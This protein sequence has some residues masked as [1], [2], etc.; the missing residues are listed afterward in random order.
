M[1]VN[2]KDKKMR[3]TFQNNVVKINT[4]FNYELSNWHIIEHVILSVYPTF[5]EFLL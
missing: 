2:G 4:A 5:S 3:N 1:S